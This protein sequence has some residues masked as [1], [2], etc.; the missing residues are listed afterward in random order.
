M[1]F[2]VTGGAGFIGSHVV[3]LLV[4][5][6]S[7]VIIIDNLS[8]GKLENIEKHLGNN[9]VKFINADII[10]ID[11][12]DSCISACDC[13]I[14][15]ACSVGVK[16]IMENRVKSL[17]SNVLNSI[18]AIKCTSKYK[19]RLIFF[20]TS[21]IYG[22]NIN[23]K[24][25]EHSDHVTGNSFRW[26]YSI[27]KSLGEYYCYAFG[28]EQNLNYNILRCFNIVGPRQVGQY[29]MVLPK[30][31]KQALGNN[32]ITVYGDGSQI[33]TFTS[34]YDLVYIV[35]NII[36]NNF[37][38]HILNLGSK[39]S[40]S[41]LNLAKMVKKLTK[42]NSDIVFV[43]FEDVFVDEFEDIENRV[44][45]ID[46]LMKKEFMTNY[47]FLEIEDIVDSVIKYYA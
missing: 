29:G 16:N 12:L 28:K 25:S 42:S 15:L 30:F 36:Y 19:K 43:S 9:Q 2:L 38:E 6:G 14:H 21:E 24:L 44:P 31:V 40:I 46:N 47:K 18:C 41:I 37:D 33:R 45:N 27:G 34:I 7:H 35:K 10:D 5:I 17:D 4:K 20:S 22:K 1:K 13:V 39:N 23:Q 8:T 11:I 26:S 3:D 32:P